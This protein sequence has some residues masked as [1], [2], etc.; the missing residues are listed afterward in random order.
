MIDDGAWQLRKWY[1]ITNLTLLP[2]TKVKLVL[3]M[4]NMQLYG[5]LVVILDTFGIN[6][7]QSRGILVRQYTI[8]INRCKHDVRSRGII[9]LKHFSNICR[10][11][12]KRFHMTIRRHVPS[13]RE[14]CE[15]QN[16]NLSDAC[17]M[18]LISLG[19]SALRGE[20]TG[21]WSGSTVLR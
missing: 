2:Y 17:K 20:G 15:L 10:R 9:C 6:H 12:T 11:L 7:V 18:C 3:R 16:G 21:R 1:P 5:R 4:F 14:K 8:L 13:E 19:F